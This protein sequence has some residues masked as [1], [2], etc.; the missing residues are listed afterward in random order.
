MARIN[1][2]I[3]EKLHKKMKIVCAMKN[4][5]IIDYINKAIQEKNGRR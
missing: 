3:E 5:T 1:V 2:E 4:I